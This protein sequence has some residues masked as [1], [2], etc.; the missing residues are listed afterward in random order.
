LQRSTLTTSVAFSQ[1]VYSILHLIH[2]TSSRS[3]T[4]VLLH[5]TLHGRLDKH[6]SSCNTASRGGLFSMELEGIFFFRFIVISWIASLAFAFGGARGLVFVN[7][8]VTICRTR[9][10]DIMG[11]LVCIFES[12]RILSTSMYPYLC[13][14]LPVTTSHLLSLPLSFSSCHHQPCSLPTSVVFFL[15]SP[16]IFSST[17]KCSSGM[18]LHFQILALQYQQTLDSTFP[19]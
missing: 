17:Y 14:F 9:S 7:W 4:L 2:F 18:P 10:G 12:C 5:H 19:R 8:Y 11:S 3:L 1:H 15:S 16:V 6:T 13:R